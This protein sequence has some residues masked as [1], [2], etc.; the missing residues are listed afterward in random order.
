[1]IARHSIIKIFKYACLLLLQFIYHKHNT[2]R[3]CEKVMDTG[4]NPKWRETQ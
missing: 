2:I 1:M 3:I 4:Q